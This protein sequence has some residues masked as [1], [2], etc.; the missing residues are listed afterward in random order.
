MEKEIISCCFT[1]YRPIKMPFLSDENSPQ[2]KKFENKLIHAIFSAYDRGCR[3]FY[4]GAAMG[5]DII[6]AECVLLLKRA[7]PDDGI[8]LVCA[9]PF[10][11]QAKKYPLDWFD[12]YNSVIDQ[13]DEVV[14]VC[15]D[16]K[17]ECYQLR[18]MYMV[19]RSDI[20]ITWYDG[21]PGGTRNTLKY[22]ERKGLQ[23]INI[24]KAGVHE[25]IHEDDYIVVFEE[26]CA[27]QL[28]LDYLPEM[29]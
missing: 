16:Y 19:D 15:D 7:H 17:R 20:V 12:R 25:Y 5:F 27:E 21:Q 14:M 24:E 23:I 10:S 18:N 29:M 28:G 2:Y 22:A 26:E 6:A 4:S 9:L 1:G 8:R 13:A 11:G 3:T